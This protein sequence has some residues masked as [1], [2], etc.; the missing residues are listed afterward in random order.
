MKKAPYF[1]LLVLVLL[2]DV[3]NLKNTNEQQHQAAAKEKLHKVAEN[4]LAKY[5][6]EPGFIPGSAINFTD[7]FVDSLIEKHVSAH[8][9]YLFSTTNVEWEGQSQIIGVGAFQNVFISFKADVLLQQEL[10]N[11]VK[12]KLRG[13]KIPGLE[14]LE[15]GF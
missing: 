14:G 4:L 1:L 9:Y 8:N 5:G 11:S 7:P 12:E 2:D 10:E 15:L 13:F 6:I 3:A